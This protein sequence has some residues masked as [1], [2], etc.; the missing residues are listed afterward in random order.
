MPHAAI[1]WPRGDEFLKLSGYVSMQHPLLQGV[2]GS[3]DG[4]NL[5]CQVSSNVEMEN[6]TYNGWLHS[7]FV[8]SVIVFSSKGLH[9]PECAYWMLA[10]Q[11]GE[12]ISCRTN[13]PGS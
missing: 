10:V 1:T 4:L 3:I 11:T 2:F 13:C 5:P 12:I 8:S 9:L 6:A 7:H